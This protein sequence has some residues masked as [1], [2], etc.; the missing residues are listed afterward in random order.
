MNDKE[1]DLIVIGG[2]VNGTGIARD[3]AM[4]GIKTLLVEKNDF[5]SGATGACS[6]MIHGGLRYMMHDVATTRK[7][8]VDSGYIQS[9]APHLLFRIP[10]LT[11][12][13]HKALAEPMETYFEA[14]DRFVEHKRG[15]PHTRLSPEEAR[16]LEPGLSPK[17]LGALTTD[18]YGID[19]F[20]LTVANSLSAQEAGADIRNHCE[21]LKL[22]RGEGGKVVGVKVRDGRTGSY[23]E[24]RS[25][26]VMN[27]GGPWGTKLADMAGATVKIRPAKGV[28][29]TLDR[30]ISN[31]G[32]ITDAIDGRNIFV[33]PHENTSIVGTTDDDYY[34]DLD[35][36]PILQDEIEYLMQGIA[37]V[38]PVIRKARILRAWAGI[39]P[40]IYNWGPNEDALSRDHVVID[41]ASEGAEGL[42]SI[43]GGKLAAYRF[44]S[45][46]AVDVIAG[47]LG[48]KAECRTHLEPLPGGDFVPDS[49]KLARE[50]GVP[51]HAVRRLI[52]RQGS[53]AVRALELTREN[54]SCKRLLCRC[55]PV[56]EAEARYVIRN[57]W[58][59]NLSDLRR[60]TR[61]SMGPCQG[62]RCAARAAAV[63]AEE[64]DEPPEAALYYLRDLLQGRFA[65]KAPA[66]GGNQLAQEEINQAVYQC[67]GRLQDY[68][69]GYGCR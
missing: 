11:P 14:Y 23:E 49:T 46:D 21:V 2:G 60:R 43:T 48:V 62:A 55:E 25:K 42:V 22:L 34:G 32:I 53:R 44:M 68:V 3:A 10:L 31:I 26:L 66:L 41:H 39:R 61:L 58:V 13:P 27:A 47:K 45:E 37:R 7:S 4:R 12:I 59:E 38:F 17:M 64:K 19:T 33:I 16:R 50:Y 54:P 51:A 30:R 67:L 69:G 8:C 28:H 1:Y 29:L 5:S 65:G 56:L 35:D 20:R 36:I 52:Y 18:E 63:L 6:G 57:E 9:I 40:T 24:I 15:K